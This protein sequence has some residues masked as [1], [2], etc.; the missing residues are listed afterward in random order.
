MGFTGVIVNIQRKL[1]VSSRTLDSH[2]FDKYI[3]DKAG[4]PKKKSFV[5]NLLRIKPLLTTLKL[6]RTDKRVADI[7]AIIVKK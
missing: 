4:N 5:H 2:Y 7:Y 1:D 6:A 3:K